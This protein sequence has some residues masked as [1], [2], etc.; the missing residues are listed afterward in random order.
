MSNCIHV[1]ELLADSGELLA[2][3]T[4]RIPY[5][6]Q[7]AGMSGLLQSPDSHSVNL[8]SAVYGIFGKI[9]PA[10]DRNPEPG[11]EP[12]P[13]DCPAS[14]YVQE[15]RDHAVKFATRNVWKVQR[16]SAHVDADDIAQDAVVLLLDD[17]QR[18][19]LDPIAEGA[20]LAVNDAIRNE[21]GSEVKRAVRFEPLTIDCGLSAPIET[22]PSDYESEADPLSKLV[23]NAL[24]IFAALV[25]NGVENEVSADA[26][27]VSIRTIERRKADVRKA[28]VDKALDT[29]VG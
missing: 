9:E 13:V 19:A 14:E 8:L 27:G 1:T 17:P 5:P 12:L 3:A 20:S 6:V 24:A 28:L 4:Q 25:A 22:I 11:S 21:Q 23:G 15:F 2:I 26:F 7:R 16:Q 10:D 18:Y 29:I